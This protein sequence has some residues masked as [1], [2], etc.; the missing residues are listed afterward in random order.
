MY[1]MRR[2]VTW[3]LAKLGWLG[4]SLVTPQ[5]QMPDPNDPKYQPKMHEHSL[6]NAEARLRSVKECIGGMQQ[7][8]TVSVVDEKGEPLSDVPLRFEL[9]GAGKGVFYDMP[10]WESEPRDGVSRFF[11]KQQPATYRL[12]VD[13]ELLVSNISTALPWKCYYN[14]YCTYADPGSFQ[15]PGRGGWLAILGPGKFSWAIKVTLKPSQYVDV[16]PE[17]KGGG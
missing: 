3:L 5:Y 17:G 15:N 8:F 10:N 1:V 13:G 6:F 14:G 4:K 7:W 11:H 9:E 2:L 16:S 12:Y